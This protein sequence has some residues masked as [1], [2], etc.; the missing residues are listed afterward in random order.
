MTEEQRA[1]IREA[2]Q[3][4][5][6]DWLQ[7]GGSLPEGADAAITAHLA[8]LEAAGLVVVPIEPTDEMLEAGNDVLLANRPVYRALV[9]A[10][11]R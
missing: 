1:A 5:L 2:V 6:H 9:A 7:S 11:P 4:V 10:R 3:L 8:A